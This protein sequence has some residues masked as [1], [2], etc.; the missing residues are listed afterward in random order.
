L[1][2]RRL[3]E[4]RQTELPEAVQLEG[5]VTEIPVIAAR[6]AEHARVVRREQPGDE[7]QLDVHGEDRD[8]GCDVQKD[9][10]NRGGEVVV[11]ALE[12]EFSHLI[13]VLSVDRRL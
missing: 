4:K 7:A 10:G 2:S 6:H 1:L 9:E 5:P 11:L 3:R 12:R 13:R 8:E